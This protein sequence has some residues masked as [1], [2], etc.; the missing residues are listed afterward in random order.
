MTLS[1]APQTAPR[2]V[3]TEDGSAVLEFAL[4]SIL[5]LGLLYGI[6]TFG[7]ILAVEHSLT[8]AAAEGA[9]AAVGAPAGEETTASATATRAA[10]GWLDGWVEPGDVTA[11]LAACDHDPATDCVR[12]RIDYPY[13]TRPVLPAFPLVGLLNPDVLRTE[14]VAS[15]G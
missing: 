5:L 9:R 7:L 2:R 15:V 10:I 8:G 14:A 4:V 3:G 6:I 1:P 12:V 11:S 13:G